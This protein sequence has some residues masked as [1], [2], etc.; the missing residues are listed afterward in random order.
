MALVQKHV[1]S[2]ESENEAVS[3][4]EINDNC[5]KMGENETNTDHAAPSRHKKLLDKKLLVVV[6]ESSP[7]KLERICDLLWQELIQVSIRLN[8]ETNFSIH[9]RATRSFGL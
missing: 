5:T 6:S 7:A 9:Y 3:L 1:D 8:L 2:T 4:D